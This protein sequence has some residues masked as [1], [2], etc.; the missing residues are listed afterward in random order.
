MPPG[1]RLAIRPALRSVSSS[2]LTPSFPHRRRRAGYREV[3]GQ[4]VHLAGLL[5][6]E[7]KTR[8]TSDVTLP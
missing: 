5:R 6:G 3:S 8:P 2:A 1:L 4:C 7:K